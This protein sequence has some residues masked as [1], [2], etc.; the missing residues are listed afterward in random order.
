MYTTCEIELTVRPCGNNDNKWQ[1]E[2]PAVASAQYFFDC[3]KPVVLSIKEKTFATR[4]TFGTWR[5]DQ[6]KA[7]VVCVKGYM[8]YS[9]DLS[10]FI[11]KNGWHKPAGGKPAL[12]IFRLKEFDHHFELVCLQ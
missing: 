9:D 8:L 7:A 5:Y 6:K 1:L 2:I 4:T 11:Y 12:L 3:R 10:S